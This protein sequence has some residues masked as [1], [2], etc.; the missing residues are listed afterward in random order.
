M[1][2]LGQQTTETLG[3][4]QSPDIESNYSLRCWLVSRSPGWFFQSGSDLAELSGIHPCICGHIAGLIC[5]VADMWQLGLEI[6]IAIMPPHGQPFSSKMLD[7]LSDSQKIQGP[8]ED[9]CWHPTVSSVCM[10][11]MR[12]HLLVKANHTAK[13]ESV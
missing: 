3:L 8:R 2:A 12:Y 4:K 1:L 6:M 13:F 5:G 11:Y 10:C 9:K 7:L